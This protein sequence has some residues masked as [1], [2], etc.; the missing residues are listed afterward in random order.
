MNLCRFIV[1]REKD[2]TILP[3]V[4]RSLFSPLMFVV[5]QRVKNP[6]ASAG[7]ARDRGSIP[8]SGRAPGE[9]NGNPH[10]RSCLGV[11]DR[12]AWQTAAHKVTK[13][14]ARMSA[15][16]AEC[17]GVHICFEGPLAAQMVKNPLANP[18]T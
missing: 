7:D 1:P 12:G 8:G 6:P 11:P 5:A 4:S 13:G 9:G 17:A 10:Q 18:E 15:R 14:Q 3:T 2:T 16:L